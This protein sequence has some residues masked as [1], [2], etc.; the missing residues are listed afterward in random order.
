M[1]ICTVKMCIDYQSVEIFTTKVC[2]KGI[3]GNYNL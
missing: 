2:E 3:H 1:V